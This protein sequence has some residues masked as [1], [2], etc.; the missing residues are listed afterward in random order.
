MTKSGKIVKK[1]RKKGGKVKQVPSYSSSGKPDPRL[2][3]GQ[4]PALVPGGGFGRPAVR[5]IRAQFSPVKVKRVAGPPA[6]AAAKRPV[7]VARR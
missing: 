7:A 1:G 3:A 6:G 5:P 4:H 2:L